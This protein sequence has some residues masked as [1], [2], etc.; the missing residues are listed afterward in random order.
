MGTLKENL[1]HFPRVG[2]LEYIGVSPERRGEVV[3]V[4]RAVLDVGTGLVGDHHAT[5]PRL[6]GQGHSKRQV[7]LI[8]A[9]HLPVVAALLG[10]ETVAPELLRRNLVVS[11]INLLAVKER[12][13][14][15]G[16]VLFE[17]TGL[18]VPCTRMEEILGE[19]GFNATRG[20]GG[21]TARVLAGG[22]LQ[23]GDGVRP[24]P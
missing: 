4:E 9:E 6:P 22:T 3:S 12:R 14:R 1:E 15:V 11:G 10:R 7:T 13:F 20:H 19:G 5:N 16:E 24:A 17:G 8:Q 2:R 23:V 18:C 21:I